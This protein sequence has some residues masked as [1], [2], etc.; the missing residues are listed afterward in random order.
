VRSGAVILKA[1]RT[2]GRSNEPVGLFIERVDPSPCS[3]V[4]P[5]SSFRTS[6][7]P[8]EASTELLDVSIEWVE[9][10]T[11]SMLRSNSSFPASAGSI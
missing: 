8:V 10:S 3:F 1:D 4:R 7:E 5:S 11:R 2:I 9:G 6:T